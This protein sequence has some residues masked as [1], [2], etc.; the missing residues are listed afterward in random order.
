MRQVEPEPEPEPE[1]AEQVGALG[2]ISFRTGVNGLEVLAC[3]TPPPPTA[4]AGK[5]FT[6]GI[7]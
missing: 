3:L 5:L 1:D 6:T 4:R 7:R 2:S